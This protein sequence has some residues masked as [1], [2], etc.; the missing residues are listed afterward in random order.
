MAKIETK[1][2]CK[3]LSDVYKKQHTLFQFHVLVGS[4]MGCSQ[5]VTVYLCVRDC[6]L[7]ELYNIVDVY[8]VELYYVLLAI[9]G[10]SLLPD[11]HN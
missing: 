11:S 7:V 2:C 10:A 1:G 8:F 4:G 6:Y 3:A 9:I 5:T